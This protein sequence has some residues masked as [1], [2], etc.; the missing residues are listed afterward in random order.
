MK[1]LWKVK[2]IT[3]SCC[4]RNSSQGLGKETGGIGNQRKNQDYA[5]HGIDEISSATQK[6]PGDLKRLVVTQTRVKDNQL[7]MVW[8]TG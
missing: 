6:S 4:T 1:K 2:E 8:K 7:K 5:D 3:N